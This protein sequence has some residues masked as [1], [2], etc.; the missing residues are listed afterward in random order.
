MHGNPVPA[1]S[2]A[3][4]TGETADPGVLQSFERLE[5]HGIFRAAAPPDSQAE[6]RGATAKFIEQAIGRMVPIG[7]L[8]MT[9]MPKQEQ[10]AH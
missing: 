6:I 7:A 1:I 8:L 4:A 9:S 2:D 3:A 5:S 10:S